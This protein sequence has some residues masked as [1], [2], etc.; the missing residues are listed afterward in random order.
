M[1]RLLDV[2]VGAR[3]Y[4]RESMERG[5]KTQSYGCEEFT[6]ARLPRKSVCM[7]GEGDRT[8]NRHR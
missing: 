1:I 4:T 6:D 7:S 2:P 3:T 5:S 8:V